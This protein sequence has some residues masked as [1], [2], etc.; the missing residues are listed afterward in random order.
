MAGNYSNGGVDTFNP[1]KQYIGVRLQQGVPLLDRDWN[2][3]EDTRRYFEQMLQQNFIGEGAPDDRGFRIG[4]P[5]VPAPNDFVIGAGRYMA[6]G[7]DVWNSAPVFYSEQAGAPALPA[8]ATADTLTVYLLPAISRV[9]SRE[10]PDLRNAQDIN[11]E[12]C[13]RDKLTWTVGVTR[14]PQV[15]PDGAVALALI[16]RPAGTTNI[17]EAMIQDQRRTHLNLAALRDDQTGLAGK[18]AAIQ[19]QIQNMQLDIQN[20]KVQLA[21]LFW[22]LTV[23]SSTGLKL[24]A[25]AV[26]V[27]VAVKDG[28][29]APVQGAYL[30]FS[31]SWGVLDPATAATD[32]SGNVTVTLYGLESPT[33]PPRSDV[34][35]LQGAIDKV[36]RATLANPGAIKYSEVKLQP[37][38]MALV[39]RYSPTQ[40][41]TDLSIDLPTAPIVDYPPVQ[42][43]TVTVH[44]KERDGAIVRGVGSVQVR[45]G[46]WVRNWAQTKI[47]DTISN[48]A[49]GAR[50]GDLMR[51]GVAA[52]GFD[53]AK[54]NTILPAVLQ[55]IHDETTQSFK[56]AVLPDPTTPDDQLSQT[57][58]LGQVIAQ[59]ATTAVGAK[60]NVAISR[61]LDQYQADPTSGVTATN[62]S[63]VRRVIVQQS[64]QT[65]AGLAQY[66]RQAFNSASRV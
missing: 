66:Q 19:A 61:Q 51:Q 2:E 10:D 62:V 36:S 22:D 27:T 23:T 63:T 60:T 16:Q 55:D 37:Q 26:S 57:G 46:M 35:V 13:Q 59:E 8:A 7:Y 1:A 54:V 17:T 56:I 52:A 12:T 20:V 58:T 21:R 29:G 34:A 18:V 38:E 15:P 30:E 49:V 48:V 39:S 14:L 28:L 25:Q 65:S 9:T 43:A 11:L 44:A 6:G 50:V 3:L 32:A 53:T 5:T 40:S 4:A 42:S 47:V 45:F 31:T 24:F 41:F 33:V 64:S